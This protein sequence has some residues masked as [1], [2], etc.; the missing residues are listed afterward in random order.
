MSAFVI[1]FTGL[2]LMVEKNVSKGKE[3]IQSGSHQF[4]RSALMQA[5]VSMGK[6]SKA[7]LHAVAAL[8]AISS[9]RNLPKYVT[10]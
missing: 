7:F 1:R 8:Q 5:K 3:E 9:Q 2:P 4:T 10:R 6:E